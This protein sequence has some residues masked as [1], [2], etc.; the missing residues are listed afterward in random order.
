MTAQLAAECLVSRTPKS[1]EIRFRLPPSSGSRSYALV[2]DWHANDPAKKK[3]TACSG[4]D[5]PLK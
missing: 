1:S 3:S 4:R 5:K 2:Y